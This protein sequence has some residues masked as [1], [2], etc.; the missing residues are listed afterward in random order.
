ARGDLSRMEVAA[1]GRLPAPTRATLIL[2]GDKDAPRWRLRA[3]S[4]ALDPALL[5]G[6]GE[7]SEP[8]AFDMVAEGVGGRAEVRGKLRRGDFS[9]I[10]QPSKLS[11]EDRV[12]RAQPLV[13]DVFDGRITAQGTADLR[14]PKDSKLKFA[15]NAR[16]LQWRS[17][18]GK[19]RVG[20][21]A[22]F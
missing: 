16:G 1:A 21:D 11:L 18:D 2:H 20:G 17:A 13:L 15:V 10:L 5:A 19:T 14:D 6:S 22:D 9:A 7:A 12:L 4:E 3:N 8:L